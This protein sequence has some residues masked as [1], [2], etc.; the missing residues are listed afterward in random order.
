LSS[1]QRREEKKEEEKK[2]T[3][4]EIDVSTTMK[5]GNG[6]EAKKKTHNY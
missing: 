4:R 5:I 3:E 6:R 1:I 2:K